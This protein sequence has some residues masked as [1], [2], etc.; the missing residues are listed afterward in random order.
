MKKLLL[1][2]MFTP[3]LAVKS[4][5][6]SFVDAD[7]DSVGTTEKVTGAF[8]STRVINAQSIEMLG[9]QTLDVRILH[10]FGEV[11]DGINQFFGLDNASMRMGFDYGISDNFTVGVGRSTFRKEVDLFGKVRV[12][13]QSKGVKNMPLSVVIVAGAMVWTEK[14]FAVV[15]PNFSD[16]SSY[17]FQVLAGRKIGENFAFQI[18]PIWVHSNMPLNGNEKDLIAIG[19]GARYK[20]SKRMAIV[21]DYHYVTEGLSNINYHPLSVGLDIETGGHIFQLHFSNATGMNER[22]FIGDT[23]GQFFKGDIRFGFNLSRLFS[24]GKRK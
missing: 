11:N 7:K 15:K 2:L 3:F 1:L 10:R 6:A 13:Q 14:S 24:I 9:K 16:R 19:G 4:Q 12:L 5:I 17:Y 23:Y 20:F 22:A 18:S 21:M 8:K